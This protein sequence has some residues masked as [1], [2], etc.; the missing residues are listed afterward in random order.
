LVTRSISASPAISAPRWIVIGALMTRQPV[1]DRVFD[2]RL[3]DQTRHP[4][5]RDRGRVGQHD[6]DAIRE[7]PLM[8]LQI[9]PRELQ[10]VGEPRVIA[11]AG[12][13]KSPQQI[14]ELHDHCLGAARVPLDVAADRVQQIE[15][16]MR[17]Q[18]HAQRR[19]ARGVR[20]RAPSAATCNSASRKRL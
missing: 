18:L 19:E 2:D 5:R 3:Q 6:A 14:R 10:F 4:D 9:E 13:Q 8:Q 12:F 16:R 20:S 11:L 1:H 7:A 17:R 15:Q